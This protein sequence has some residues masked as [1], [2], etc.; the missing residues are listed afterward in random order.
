MLPLLQ[1]Q[2]FRAVILAEYLSALL[3]TRRNSIRCMHTPEM[4][5]MV[6]DLLWSPLPPFSAPCSYPGSD[7]GSRPSCTRCT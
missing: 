1:A 3:P 2:K 4:P 5:R 6:H 7:E